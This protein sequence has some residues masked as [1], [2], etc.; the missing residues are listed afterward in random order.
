MHTCAV[1]L[2]TLA[3]W[4]H[5]CVSAGVYGKEPA[6]RPLHAFLGQLEPPFVP[7][8][9]LPGGAPSVPIPAPAHSSTVLMTQ[10]AAAG[11]NPSLKLDPGAPQFLPQSESPG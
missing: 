6:L 5:L 8:N 9:L 10:L 1:M 3:W 11:G 4:W 7:S 2:G